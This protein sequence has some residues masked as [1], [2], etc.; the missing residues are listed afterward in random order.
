MTRY[1]FVASG[2]G[3]RSFY[4]EG[5]LVW[6]KRNELP[7]VHIASTSSGN[8][9]VIDYLLWDDQ[10]E[11]LPPVLTR[12]VRL[13]VT[14]VFHIFSNFLGLR[15]KL[16][17]TGTHLF[18]VDKDSCR[19]SLLLDDPERR[20]ILARH[21]EALRWDIRATNLSKRQGHFF[22]VNEILAKID[23][24][25]L[26]VFMDAFLAGITT[27]PYFKAITIDGDYYIEG[28]YLDNTPLRTLFEDDE[29]DEIIAVDFTDYD[30]HRELEKLYSSSTFS[31]PFTSIDT[32]LL[33]SDMQLSLPNARVFTQAKLINEML[34]AMG[35]KSA[36]I[37]GKRYYAK[38]LHVLR[39][40]DL[41]SMT[42]SLKDSSAQKRYFELGLQEAATLFPT[43]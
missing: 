30:Y 42:I 36:E 39:P 9:I 41:E 10:N 3:Y 29:V 20:A 28:G 32:H 11:E 43:L 23:D 1:G 15:P 25:S 6:L 7:V 37:D 12:T 21:L 34:A 13:S 14:D 18:S 4:T 26:D 40:K 17:P 31:L 35:K 19:K 5:V 22:K 27:I 33:V 38:P 24:A 2:G 8:N 16:L